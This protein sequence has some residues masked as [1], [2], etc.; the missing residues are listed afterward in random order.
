VPQVTNPPALSQALRSNEVKYWKITTK[1]FPRNLFIM[2]TNLANGILVAAL[3]RCH[4]HNFFELFLLGK[5]PTTGILGE[6]YLK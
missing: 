6:F 1:S 2:A 4:Q 3:R 5:T